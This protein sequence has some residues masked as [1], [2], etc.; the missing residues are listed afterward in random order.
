M[1]EN[2][3]AFSQLPLPQTLLDNLTAMQYTTMT[4]VQALTL[5]VILNGKDVIA[6][7]KTGSGK[8]AAFGLGILSAI[9]VDNYAIQALVICPTR[10]LAEQVTNELRRLARLMSN[11]KILTL[12]GGTPIIHQI[13]S[14][15]HSAHIVVGTP[16]RLLDHLQKNTLDLA[17]LRLLVLDEADRMLD[18]GFEEDIISIIKQAPKQRQTLLF[19][20]TYPDGIQHI[21][22]KIQQNAEFLAVDEVNNQIDQHFYEVD[23]NSREQVL[24]ALLTANPAESTIIFC[25]TKIA[26]QEVDHYLSK[27]G[28][29][30]IALHGDLE[31]RDREQVLL[32]F[33]NKSR[34]ILIATDVAARGLDIKELDLVI[35]YQISYDPQVHV[36]RVG[37]TGRAGETGLAITLVAA[38]EMPKANL[39]EELGSGKLNWRTLNNTT[40]DK[41]RIIKPTMQT[42]SLT[43]GRKNKIRPGDIL[44]ALTKD[45]G[46]DGALI[47][48]ISITDLYSYVAINRKAI[49]K[50]LDYFK[51]GKIKGKS[52]RAKS[53]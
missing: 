18:M 27:L 49:N 16:G 12:C 48:K 52:V 28:F 39:L 44:G 3:T 6:K 10:E 53:L 36:H 13:N 40:F 47:G 1:L 9:K 19:S 2:T 26:C 7:A 45:A 35:N 46:I 34:S 33:S 24:A 43:I 8:T 37:R 29:S 50:V 11:V 30:V 23:N 42:V 17:E 15:E 21:S 20:A 51:Q 14:L 38:N 31:Q 41:S 5:P 32:Q 22:R 4:P 25:N